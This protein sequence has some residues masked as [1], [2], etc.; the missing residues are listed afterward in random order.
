MTGETDTAVLVE[1][2]LSDSP[3]CD[4]RSIGAS[5]I[6]HCRVQ[7]DAIHLLPA[8]I[9]QRDGQHLVL[10]TDFDHPKKLQA[11]TWWPIGFEVVGDAEEFHLWPKSVIE[12]VGAKGPSM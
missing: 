3:R 1:V 9:V 10:T 4:R 11:I 5:S 12:L 6:L 8:Q 7:I 2:S